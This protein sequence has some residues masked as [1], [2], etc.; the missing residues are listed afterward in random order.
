MMIALFLRVSSP[1]L[2]LFFLF[3]LLYSTVSGWRAW[4]PKP[5]NSRS[6]KCA[7]EPFEIS[8]RGVMPAS[9]EDPWPEAVTGFDP[10]EALNTGLWR[11]LGSSS[12][13]YSSFTLFG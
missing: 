10:L 7:S 11:P 1:F 13:S 4:I 3:S 6:G 5:Q 2:R 9:P 12:L 8:M